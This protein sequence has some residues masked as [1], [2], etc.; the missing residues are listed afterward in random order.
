MR[1]E[2]EYFALYNA[3]QRADDEFQAAVVRQFGKRTAGTARY[4]SSR[5]NA[6]VKALAD[7]YHVAANKLV[8]WIQDSRK[9]A[10]NG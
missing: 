8:D 1:N 9:V 3:A 4:Q 6:E 10:S 5:H 2:A 7:R